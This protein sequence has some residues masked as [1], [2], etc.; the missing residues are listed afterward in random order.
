MVALILMTLSSCLAANRRVLLDVGDR[1]AIRCDRGL[2]EDG[3]N[4]KVEYPP[5]DLDNHHYI[6]RSDFN[7]SG[8]SGTGVGSRDG[9]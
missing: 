3:D 9:D 1:Q 4:V 2:I 7:Q 5:S 6:P 8:D